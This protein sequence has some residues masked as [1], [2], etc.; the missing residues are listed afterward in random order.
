MVRNTDNSARV[1]FSHVNTFQGCSRVK[2]DL[3]LLKCE[4]KYFY[5]NEY[6]D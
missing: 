2:Q 6:M 3:Y 5:E 4:T 1:I